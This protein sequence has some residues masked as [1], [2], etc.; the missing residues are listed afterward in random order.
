MVENLEQHN[1]KDDDDIIVLGSTKIDTKSGHIFNGF[2]FSCKAL[3]EN[4]RRQ[5][6][7]VTEGSWCL[8]ADCTFRIVRDEFARYSFGC[9]S[10][11]IDNNGVASYHYRPFAFA[12]FPTERKE[13]Y[14]H[15]F[16][17]TS[18]YLLNY[19]G[20]RLRSNYIVGDR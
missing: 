18:T 17:S 11:V 16:D 7:G 6:C 2:S 10:L 19:Y 5:Q 1:Q 8:N 9:T 4:A 14:S 15:L 3:L 20:L 12:L 13:G